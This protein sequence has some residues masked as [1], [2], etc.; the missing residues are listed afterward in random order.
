MHTYFLI[1]NS[2]VRVILVFTLLTQHY[3]RV[4]FSFFLH[5]YVKFY[6]EIQYVLCLKCK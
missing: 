4:F 3:A 5:L 1:I 2:F 6:I